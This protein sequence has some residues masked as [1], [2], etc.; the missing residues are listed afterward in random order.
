MVT[1][2]ATGN[3]LDSAEKILNIVQ[4]NVTVYVFDLRLVIS[5][6]T[7]GKIP[8]VQNFMNDETNALR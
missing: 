3:H 4:K 8:H 2:R 6:P 1:N 7:I 5:G